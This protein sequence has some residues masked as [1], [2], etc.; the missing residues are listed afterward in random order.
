MISLALF[1]RIEISSLEVFD[2][3]EGKD[4]PVVDFLDDCRNLFP[5]EFCGCTQ[6]TLASDELEAILARPA[7]HGY[8]LNSCRG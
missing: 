6:T 1:D 2:E 8:W 5:S 4:C 3:R 7:A